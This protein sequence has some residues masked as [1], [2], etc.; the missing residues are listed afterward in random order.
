LV[1]SSSHAGR[2]EYYDKG[3][4]TYPAAFYDYLY[5]ELAIGPASVIADIG[6]ATGRVT[7][8]FL[9]RGS[10]VYAVEPDKDMMRILQ[11]NLNQYE[12]CIPIMN[13]AESTGIPSDAVDLVFCGNAY[14]WFERNKAIP[15]FKRILRRDGRN[16]VISTLG[17]PG[18]SRQVDQ[19]F[20]HVK[21]IVGAFAP[22][23]QKRAFNRTTPFRQGSF[24]TQEFIFDIDQTFEALLNGSLSSAFGIL[25]QG[26]DFDRYYQLFKE[27][28]NEHSLD[29]KIQMEFK[30]TC[31]IGNADDLVE[32]C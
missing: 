13:S 2:A 20:A 28:F 32:L 26:S 16:V 4:P 23:A 21:S 29:G 7:K 14:E 27:G 6:S 15:E 10:R 9:E 18:R 24:T 25:P 31:M 1:S 30:L 17:D 19:F 5:S 8:G 3:R 12:N 22:P 11:D